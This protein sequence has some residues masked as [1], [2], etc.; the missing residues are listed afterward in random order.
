MPQNGN[1]QGFLCHCFL[2]GLAGR[3]LTM[4][5]PP[6]Y[7]VECDLAKHTA[8]GPKLKSD[9]GSRLQMEVGLIFP[10]LRIKITSKIKNSKISKK[11]AVPNPFLPLSR[12]SPGLFN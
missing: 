4:R 9:L 1:M 6:N 10:C 7:L 8:T 11:R 2:S 3:L 5:F 12:R